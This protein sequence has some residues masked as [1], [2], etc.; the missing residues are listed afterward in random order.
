MG[1][2]VPPIQP[3]VFGPQTWVPSFIFPS[4]VQRLGSNRKGEKRA[5][6]NVPSMTEETNLGLLIVLKTFDTDTCYN[7]DEP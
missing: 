2:E 5:V 1:H 7:M 3:S 6:N 4:S